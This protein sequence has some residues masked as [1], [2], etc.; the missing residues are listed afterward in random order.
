MT[1]QP[2]VRWL[3]FIFSEMLQAVLVFFGY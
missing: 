3:V 2:F 1:A